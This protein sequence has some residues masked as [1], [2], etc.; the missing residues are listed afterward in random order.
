MYDYHNPTFER[1]VSLP[2][3]SH[4]DSAIHEL[5]HGQL[6][7]AV[8]VTGGV[9]FAHHDNAL[10]EPIN[11]LYKTELFHRRA[12]WKMREAR[13]PLNPLVFQEPGLWKSQ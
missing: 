13:M 4:A 8:D 9:E 1:Q 12:P 2:G 3:L 5:I 6:H 10:A 11:G 7:G